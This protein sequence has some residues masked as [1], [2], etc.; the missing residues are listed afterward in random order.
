MTQRLPVPAV[1]SVGFALLATGLVVATLTGSVDMSPAEV[2]QVLH[3]RTTEGVAALD[4]QERLVSDVRA[5]RAGLAALVGAVLAIVGTVLQALV[6]NPLADPAILGGTAGAGLGAVCV[7]V[8][9]ASG[10]V[11]LSVG[12]F[13]GSAFGFGLTFLLAVRGGGLSPLRLVLSG[14]AVSFLLGA[15]TNLVVLRGDDRRLRSALFWQLGSVA[16]ARWADLLLPAV[17]LTLGALLLVARARRLDLLSFGDLTAQALGVS[18]GRLRAELFVLTSVLTGICVALAGGVGFV[19][20]V[21]PHAVRLLVGPSHRRVVP[22]SALVGA[23]FLVWADTA[24]RVLAEPADLPLGVV[25]ALVGAPV[26]AI[27]VGGRMRDERA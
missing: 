8:L 19:A 4:L 22:L 18:P 26:F 3:T 24:A 7:L 12:A 6:R 25:T 10:G 21:V 20:L 5:P 27:L 1:A 17:A 13:A 16:Q 11:T 23:G 14:I 15:V 9:G 2:V